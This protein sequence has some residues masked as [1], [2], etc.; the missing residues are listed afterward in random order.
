MMKRIWI[1]V[2][3]TTLSAVVITTTAVAA[4]RTTVSTA[5]EALRVLASDRGTPSPST[6]G[7]V[8]SAVTKVTK[9]RA[10]YIRGYGRKLASMGTVS[11]VDGFGGVVKKSTG[12]GRGIT[13]VPVPVMV[14]G[15]L[16]RLKMPA[17]GTGSCNVFALLTGQGTVRLQVLG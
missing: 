16:Y 11:C 13:N 3:A 6:G 10:Y 1:V 15:R 4:S 5:S 9:A 17:G 2:A 7:A 12:Y 8:A 14:P